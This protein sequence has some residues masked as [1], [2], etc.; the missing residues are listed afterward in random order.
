MI[1]EAFDHQGFLNAAMTQRYVGPVETWD[2]RALHISDLT[3]CVRDIW[4]RR[5]GY[6]KTP[7]S[8]QRRLTMIRGLAIEAEIR[9]GLEPALEEL[10]YAVYHA[11][12][13]LGPIGGWIAVEKRPRDRGDRRRRRAAGARRGRSPRR[14]RG[15]LRHPARANLRN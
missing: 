15:Q 3:A 9:E 5:N 14:A 7:V 13:T 1:R 8:A 10:G 12:S 4:F 6:D 2:D 11:S